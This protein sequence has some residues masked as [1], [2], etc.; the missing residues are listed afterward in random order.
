MNGVS[1]KSLKVGRCLAAVLFF[2]LPGLLWA[3]EEASSSKDIHRNDSLQSEV[4]LKSDTLFTLRQEPM[5]RPTLLSYVSPWRFVGY[6]TWNV[7]EGLNANLDLGVVAAAS[8]NSPMRAGSF[9]T[10]LSLLYAKP[11]SERWTAALGT[12]LSRFSL[13]HQQ[14]N[15][16][17]FE[18]LVNYMFNEHFSASVFATYNLGDYQAMP[19]RYGWMGMGPMNDYLPAKSTV[20]LQFN[21]KVNPSLSFHVSVWRGDR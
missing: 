10:D 14:Q 21:Y 11:L 17:S 20:G 3:Q 15:I 1:L 6:G 16:V 19:L 4:S 5:G 7:H 13:W 8:K 18:G 12:T 9:Y 2:V